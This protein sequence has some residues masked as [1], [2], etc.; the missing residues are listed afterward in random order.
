MKQLLTIVNFIHE[1]GYAIRDLDPYSIL[2]DENDNLYLCSF[3]E[4]KSIKE[5]YSLVV[6]E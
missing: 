3:A 1:K 2:V 5:L 6:R 4:T